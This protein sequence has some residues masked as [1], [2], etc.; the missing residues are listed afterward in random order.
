[1]SDKKVLGILVFYQFFLVGFIDVGLRQRKQKKFNRW[2]FA[3]K[4]IGIFILCNYLPIYLTKIYAQKYCVEK[5]PWGEVSEGPPPPRS[6]PVPQ[7][8]CQEED[9]SREQITRFDFERKTERTRDS[10][11]RWRHLMTAIT[12]VFPSARGRTK[13]S[14]PRSVKYRVI[15][16][17]N[18][19]RRSLVPTVREKVG[20]GRF[21]RFGTVRVLI[22][23]KFPV[24]SVDSLVLCGPGY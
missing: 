2:S 11:A 24:Q 3:C 19:E 8:K 10:R 23:R 20:I 13:L 14:T 21:F 15:S 6:A 7:D 22:P 1:M 17:E 16:L 12:Q 9:L 18:A 4:I 5:A